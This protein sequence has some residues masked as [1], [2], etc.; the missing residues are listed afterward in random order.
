M[1]DIKE[2]DTLHRSKTPTLNVCQCDFS[3]K[4]SDKFLFKL[5]YV[6]YDLIS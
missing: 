6:L 1:I 2:N 5:V 3:R 4:K